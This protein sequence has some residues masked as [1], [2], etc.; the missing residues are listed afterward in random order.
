MRDERLEGVE[1]LEG[2][3]DDSERR[4]RRRQRRTRMR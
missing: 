1:L 3:L 2:V 4:R